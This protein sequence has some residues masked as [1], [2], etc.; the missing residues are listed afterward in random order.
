M[1]TDK[2]YYDGAVRVHMQRDYQTDTDVLTAKVSAQLSKRMEADVTR[3]ICHELFGTNDI[4]FVRTM[5]EVLSHDPEVVAKVTALRASRRI[6][7]PTH[8]IG[9]PECT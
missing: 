6:G 1:T 4:D 5:M 8:K 2:T 9:A 3:R 7:V